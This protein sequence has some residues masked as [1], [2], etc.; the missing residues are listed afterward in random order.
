LIRQNLTNA[1]GEE[2]VA[3]ALAIHTLEPDGDEAATENLIDVLKRGSHWSAK[4]QAAISL[5]N[6]SN[7]ASERA[8][9]D[10]VEHDVAY[11]VRL[12]ALKSLLA[13]WKV[14]TDDKESKEIPGLIERPH[15]VMYRGEGMTEEYQKNLTEARERLERLRDEYI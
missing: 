11:L 1:K 4:M 5:G 12:H 7:Q 8:L 9:L 13:R 14:K 10:A 6:F 15:S 3:F 2:K